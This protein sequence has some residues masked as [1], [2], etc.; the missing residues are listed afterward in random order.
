MSK[1]ILLGC[2]EVPGYGGASTA[3]YRLFEKMQRD[4]YAVHYCN[5]IEQ[6]DEDYYRYIFGKDFGN[7]KQLNN[8]HTISLRLPLYRSHIELSERIAEIKPDVLLGSGFIAAHLMKK[9]CPEKRTIFLTTGCQQMKEL[10]IR[11]RAKDF[12]ELENKLNGAIGNLDIFSPEE[13]AALDLCDLIITNSGMTDFL[14]EKFF[15]SYTGK[16]Y[17]DVIWFSEWIYE[18]ALAYSH[19][20]KP[21]EER[22]IDVL[23]ISSSWSRPEKG[24]EFVKQV[25]YKLSGMKIHIVGES[26]EA[27]SLQAVCHG[28]MRN[29][30]EL[31]T[32]LGKAKTVVCPSLFDAAPGILFEGS[33]MDCNLVT[34]KN[35]GNWEIC[36][37]ALLVDPF[38]VDNFAQKIRRSVDQ[39]YP[40]HMHR[41]LGKKCYQNLMETILALD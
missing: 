5:L 15:P 16:I 33:A 19:F 22:N 13:R 3:T 1:S 12:M 28:V 4:G 11:K 39:K 29:R 6:Q 10:I 38:S 25:L 41:F 37:E 30:S 40:D 27:H 7:P 2:Y 20:K 31:F 9:S 8:V 23:F 21:F 18:D 36:N 14:F 24:F 17:S 32:L 35:C 26:E 34:S